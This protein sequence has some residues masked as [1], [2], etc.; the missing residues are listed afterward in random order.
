ME[1]SAPSSGGTGANISDMDGHLLV[2]EPI[3]YKADI[4]TS[5]GAKDAISA[6][7]H[8]ITAGETHEDMLI[9]PKVLVGSLKG[10]IGQRVLGT[11]GR[12]AAKPGQQAPWVLNDMSGD[13]GSVND[14]TRYLTEQTASTISAPAP[15]VDPSSIELTPELLAALGN[16]TGKS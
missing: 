7:V 3:E 15:A 10:R 14:A 5:L 13:P 16:L 12:G 8:D 11:L 6:T 1:F 4:L 9:F 2:V